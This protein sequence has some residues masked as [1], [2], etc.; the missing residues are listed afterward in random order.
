MKNGIDVSV[1]NGDINWQDVLGSGIEFAIIRCGYGSPDPNQVDKKYVQNVQGCQSAGLPFG[2]YH[3]GYALSE[4][5][6]Q[7]E[8]NFCLS[9]LNGVSCDYPVFYDVE[10]PSMFALGRDKLTSVINAFCSV[11]EAAGYIPGVYMSTSYAE[12]NVNIDSISADRWI[13]QYNDTL[14]FSGNAD[15][16]Q[17]TSS[18]SIPGISGRVDMNYC[19]KEY[20]GSPAPQ[21]SWAPISGTATVTADLLNVRA[22]NS[23]NYP[24]LFQVSQGNS[25]N[26]VGDCGNGW[27]YINCIHGNGYVSAQ[28]VSVDS[29]NPSPTPSEDVI[30]V[31]ECNCDTLN[32]RAGAN[33]NSDVL[34]QI[35]N[36]NSVNILEVNPEGWLR[37]ECLH[38]KG[39]C[40]AGYINWPVQ[41]S[42]TCSADLLNVRS[43][44]GTG[45]DVLYQVKNGDSVNILAQLGE[46]YYIDCMHGRGYCSTE[47]IAR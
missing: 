42:G 33:T 21:P 4:S 5:E 40:A 1:W 32:V 19:Y 29:N 17:Y 31:G 8:A 13:A 16:W 46:W 43:G 18:G 28:Y 22:G 23:T 34:F 39:Y 35:S 14:T 37:I 47:Y 24:V 20:S 15:I 27:Y 25:L 38:G 11:I 45:Y 2:I 41:A 44:A 12:N 6:A 26:L 10:E 36:G 30:Y 3:Y 7:N 9:I